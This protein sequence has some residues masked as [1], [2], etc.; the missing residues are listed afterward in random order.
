MSKLDI[1]L[2]VKG[3]IAKGIEIE[4]DWGEVGDAK[5]AGGTGF[6]KI[7]ARAQLEIIVLSEKPA[8]YKGHFN[9]G[10][11]VPCSRG[12]CALCARGI[13]LQQRTVFAVYDCQRSM[14]G[15]LELGPSPTGMVRDYATNSGGLRGLR[16]RI[17]RAGGTIK[18]RIEVE[19]S[20][21]SLVPSADLPEPCDVS[22]ALRKMWAD[23]TSK[24][25]LKAF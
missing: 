2:R 25:L 4:D 17:Q 15:M 21:L 9:A 14:S 23:Q 12:T 11:M 1:D 3:M 5:L 22:A 18:G 7:P 20:G 13:G 10:R 6:I 8:S 16:L 19:L 24:E